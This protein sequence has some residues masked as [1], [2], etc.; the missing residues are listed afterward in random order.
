MRGNDNNLS[1]GIVQSTNINR[2]VADTTFDGH[3]L[4]NVWVTPQGNERDIF[5]YYSQTKG[6]E[7]ITLDDITWWR[8]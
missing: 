3:Q 5:I 6:V 7:A 8:Q 1:E 4:S 2:F